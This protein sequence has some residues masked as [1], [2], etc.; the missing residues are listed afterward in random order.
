MSSLAGK[1]A[2]RITLAALA[3]LL[4]IRAAHSDGDGEPGFSI[5]DVEA[6]LYYHETGSFG[7]DDVAS[8]RVALRNTTIG[9]GDALSPSS[10]LL[11]LVSVEGCFTCPT[12]DVLELDAQ[13]DARK[14]QWSSST[15][16]S[17]YFTS[18][19]RAVIPFLIHETG[20][21]PLILIAKIPGSAS[22]PVSAT[23]PFQCGE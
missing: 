8:G 15:Q 18:K 6:R 11:V 12:K 5:A 4:P 20:C 7:D 23:V 13:N 16:L 1:I 3:C 19:G 21:E 2:I 10:A 17:A 9:S 14:E 22:A